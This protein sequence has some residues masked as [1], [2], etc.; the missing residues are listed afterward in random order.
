MAATLMRNKS[1]IMARIFMLFTFLL[2]YNLLSAQCCSESSHC[3]FKK[4]ADNSN[5]RSEHEVPGDFK[6][7]GKGAMIAYLLKSGMKASAFEVK[8]EGSDK[9]L[10]IIHE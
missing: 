6:H 3:D 10:I 8:T 1:K 7:E 2:S 5:F 9:F 4:L